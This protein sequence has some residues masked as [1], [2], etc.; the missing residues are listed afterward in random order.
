ML[1]L[2][3]NGMTITIKYYDYV[4]NNYNILKLEYPNVDYEFW[5]RTKEFKNDICGLLGGISFKKH[6][7][8][9]SPINSDLTIKKQQD[10][11]NASVLSFF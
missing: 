3:E 4:I 2:I 8:T 1:D 5:K 11:S 10:R 9:A 7:L 6:P